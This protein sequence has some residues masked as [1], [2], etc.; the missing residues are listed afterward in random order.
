MYTERI[1]ICA[2]QFAIPSVY[3]DYYTLI[4]TTGVTAPLHADVV[5]VGGVVMLLHKFDVQRLWVRTNRIW[6]NNCRDIHSDKMMMVF[7]C[8]TYAKSQRDYTTYGSFTDLNI[9][10]PDIP[11][12]R[13]STLSV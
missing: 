4:K 13:Y 3:T 6:Q 9:K 7:I 1:T 11:R 2:A 12:I 5:S 8:R 10:Y